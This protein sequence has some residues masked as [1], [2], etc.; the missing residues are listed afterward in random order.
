MK[1]TGMIRAL[2]IDPIA[3]VSHASI[4]PWSAILGVWESERYFVRLTA[5]VLPEMTTE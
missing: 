4:S 2:I 5:H 3:L 1:H